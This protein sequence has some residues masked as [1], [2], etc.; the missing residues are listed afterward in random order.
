MPQ[1]EVKDVTYGQVKEN[2]DNTATQETTVMSG[3]VGDTYGFNRWDSMK[4]TYSM[5][6]TADQIKA[7]VT[8][9]AQQLVATKYPNT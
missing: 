8:T 3:V 1:Y 9:E 2:G 4:V 7:Q 5:S 6:L